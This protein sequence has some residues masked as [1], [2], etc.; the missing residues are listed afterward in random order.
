MNPKT[1]PLSAYRETSIRTAG[2][3][4]LIIMLYDE[5]IKQIK[6]ALQDLATGKSRYDAVNASLTKAQEVITELS[7]SLDFERGG[8]IARNLFSLYL[9]FNRQ[10]VEGNISKDSQPL[11]DVQQMLRS[12]RDSW[13]EV[14]RHTR[15]D[16]AVVSANINVAG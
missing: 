11:Q 10:L 13:A 12:L 2:Q 6:S 9:F 3:G 14:S 15:D 16:G 4:K 1:N 7:V 5:A 8:E